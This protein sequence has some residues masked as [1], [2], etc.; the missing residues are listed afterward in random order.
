MW[1][2]GMQNGIDIWENSL[3]VSYQVSILLPYI[4]ASYF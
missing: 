2:A 4:P 1:L 3:A